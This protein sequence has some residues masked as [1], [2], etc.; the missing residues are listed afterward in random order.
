MEI[1][2][3]KRITSLID[4]AKESTDNIKLKTLDYPL[5]NNIF[6]FIISL[7]CLYKK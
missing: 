4:N 5:F 1:I 3:K 2:N 6:N 7:I